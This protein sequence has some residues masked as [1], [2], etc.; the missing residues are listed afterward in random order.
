M[1][2]TGAGGSQTV[3]HGL[4]VIPQVI[5]IKR[6]DSS[7]GWIM[8]NEIMGHSKYLILNTTAA[9]ASSAVFLMQQIQHLLSLV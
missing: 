7:N 6:L 9:E 2:Y 5:I 8:Y 3:G 4:G 1:T